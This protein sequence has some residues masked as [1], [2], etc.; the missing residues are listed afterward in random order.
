MKKPQKYYWKV[1]SLVGNDPNEFTSCVIKHGIYSLR[2]EIGKRTKSAMTENGIFVFDTRKNARQF[3][4][5]L[6]FSTTRIFRC[7]VHGK[8]IIHPIFY[9]TYE[10]NRYGKKSQFTRRTFPKG[11]KSFPAITLIKQ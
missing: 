4:H 5:T 7:M 11:T 1:V 3:K 8:E 9:A 10:L 2:Y 6:F